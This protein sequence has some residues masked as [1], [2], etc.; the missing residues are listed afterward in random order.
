MTAYEF[1]FDFGTL[2]LE[3]ADE[4]AFIGL[5]VTRFERSYPADVER[6]M[7]YLNSRYG[8]KP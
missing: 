3:V 2:P 8:G 7:A 4:F 1:T 6:I 5:I